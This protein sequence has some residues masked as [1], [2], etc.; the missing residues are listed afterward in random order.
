M[1]DPWQ[2]DPPDSN[3]TY[4][5]YF[6]LRRLT[7]WMKL[8]RYLLGGWNI[9]VDPNTMSLSRGDGTITLSARPAARARGQQVCLFWRVAQV[10]ENSTP[11]LRISATTIGGVMPS[12]F[13]E[14]F[15]VNLDSSDPVYFVADC[16]MSNG[17]VQSCVLRA[18]QT[19]S[20]NI[21]D[22]TIPAQV[23]TPPATCSFVVAKWTAGVT[24]GYT[25]AI[26]VTPSNTWKQAATS[27]SPGAAA[28]LLWWS[29]TISE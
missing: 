15:D 11:K 21:I 29:Y 17:A 3:A 12:N 6:T 14:L 26:N 19:T 1:T 10:E 27:P 5:G 22:A 7:A 13:A 28:Y 25:Q 20:A 18:E 16:T 9:R 2:I 24:C 23:G 4:E 8:F